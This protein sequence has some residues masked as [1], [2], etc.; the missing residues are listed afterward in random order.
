MISVTQLSSVNAGLNALSA[1]LLIIGLLFIKSRNIAAHKACMLAAC[2]SSTLFLISY[3]VYHY[4][5]GSVAFKGQGAVRILYFAILLTHT[6]LAVAVVPMALITLVRAL[7][8][9]FD[10]H[11][12]I[13]RWT[14]PIW[15]YVS[16]TGVVV[17]WMLYW[18]VPSA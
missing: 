16:V 13:A 14:L 17:Y 5:V 8:S 1:L 2:A 4:H 11:R 12:R 6:I 7:R 3:L 9:R 18:L 10:A 15:L